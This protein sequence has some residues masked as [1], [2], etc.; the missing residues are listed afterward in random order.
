MRVPRINVSTSMKTKKEIVDYLKKKNYNQ[1]VIDN[2][3]AKLNEYNYINDE[4]YAKYYAC[5]HC[6]KEGNRKLKFDLIKKGVSEEIVSKVLLDFDENL[7]DI[8]RIAEK[9]LK[10][11]AR[12]YKTKSKLFSHLASKGYDYDNINKVIGEFNWGESNED[13]V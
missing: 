1:K 5:C 4:V 13:W 7:D 9:Y 2:V 11:K 8:R 6:T 10:G 12:D 3:I